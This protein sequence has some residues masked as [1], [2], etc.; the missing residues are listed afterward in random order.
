MIGTVA[1]RWAARLRTK[2]ESSLGRI[3]TGRAAAQPSPPW[4]VLTPTCWWPP[5]GWP[6]PSPVAAKP[7]RSARG[8]GG[9]QQLA[10]V[11]VGDTGSCAPLLPRRDPVD[12]RAPL[13]VS[14]HKTVDRHGARG[15]RCGVIRRAYPQVLVSEQE[16]LGRSALVRDV[17]LDGL[18]RPRAALNDRLD[19]GSGHCSCSLTSWRRRATSTSSAS[20]LQAITGADGCQTIREQLAAT[21]RT[22]LSAE[23]Y[24]GF[25]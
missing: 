7:S 19:R 17:D 22:S 8:Y 12:V 14:T 1:L 5:S 2:P 24:L 13:L 6:R 20:S 9:H 15:R 23:C 18:A 10:S 16:L 25:H 21:S 11:P 4:N 3:R